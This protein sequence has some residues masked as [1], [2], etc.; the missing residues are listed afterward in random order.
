MSRDVTAPPA[1]SVGQVVRRRRASDALKPSCPYCGCAASAVYDSR[2]DVD[3]NVYLRRRECAEC[4]R[5]WPTVEDLDRERFARELQA[6]GLTL[7]DVEAGGRR[8]V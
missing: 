2:G 3:R 5:D 6:R 1:T 8:N 7:A 4:G